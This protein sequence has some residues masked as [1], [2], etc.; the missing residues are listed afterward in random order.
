M[1]IG[2]Q[3]LIQ[4][5]VD[6]YDLKLVVTDE[7]HRFGVKTERNAGYERAFTTC[8]CHECNTYTENTGTDSVWR[9]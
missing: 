2:T 5:N 7:Q 9:S 1:I 3:A 6:F 8:T 4:D